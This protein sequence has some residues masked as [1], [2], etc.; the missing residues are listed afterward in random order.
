LT[1]S[2]LRL[3]YRENTTRNYSYYPIILNDEEELLR[4]LDR[5]STNSINARRYFFPCLDELPY[6]ESANVPISRDISR[7]VLCLPLYPDLDLLDVKRICDI[8]NSTLA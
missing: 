3:K 7:R 5:L 8:V 2:I 4:V 6:V 1:S